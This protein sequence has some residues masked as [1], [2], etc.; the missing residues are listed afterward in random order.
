MSY[1][2]AGM[3]REI[4]EDI[5]S[6]V[7]G[8]GVYRAGLLDAESPE[9]FDA[10][11]ESLREEWKERGDHTEV[12]KWMEVRAEMMKTRM[13]MI[14]SVCIA[15]RFPPITKDSD[16][17]SHFLTNDAECNNSHLKSVKKHTQSGFSGTIE[18]VRSLVDTENEEFSQAIV[19]VSEDYELREEFE[20]FVV[21]D[22][23]SRSKD[24]RASYIEKLTKATMAELHA[25]EGPQ[26]FGWIASNECEQ[27]ECNMDMLDCDMSSLD[28]SP[29]D[30]ARLLPE[31]G[32][33]LQ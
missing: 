22:F 31:R 20:K 27:N 19:G 12:F 16:I 23:L 21:P 33:L 24:E 7:D 13:R 17:P 11:L 30:C 4:V 14:A 32:K 1:G 6:K 26:S 29:T 25:A 2:M 18:A 9:E 28:L 3:Q 8:D 15:A 10:K 5:F